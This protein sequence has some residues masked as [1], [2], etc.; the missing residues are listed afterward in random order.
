MFTDECRRIVTESRESW[1]GRLQQGLCGYNSAVNAQTTYGL[2]EKLFTQR[3]RN[4]SFFLKTRFS[5]CKYTVLIC[6]NGKSSFL[7]RLYLPQISLE[8]NNDGQFLLGI[9]LSDKATSRHQDVQPCR[10][11]SFYLT[12]TRQFDS[13]CVPW[14]CGLA[15]D[16]VA[17]SWPP[18]SDTVGIL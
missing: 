2:W 10:N 16:S 15:R 17:G 1:G 12:R 11:T 9:V 14:T 13:L 18:A 7:G 3:R 5:Y 6:D 4:I 8:I